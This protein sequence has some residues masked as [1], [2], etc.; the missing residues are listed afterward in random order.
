MRVEKGKSAKH[1]FLSTAK[2]SFNET[3]IEIDKFEQ[4][5]DQYSGEL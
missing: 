5:N 4:N 1:F 3:F 2:I